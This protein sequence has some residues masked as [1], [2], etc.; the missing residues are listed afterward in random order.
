MHHMPEAYINNSGP[1]LASV[2]RPRCP[3]CQTR[4][5]LARIAPVPRGFNLHTFECGKCGHV[6]IATAE[7]DPMKSQAGWTRSELKPPR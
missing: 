6:H 3:K 5:S 7:T 1:S 2:E 4:M